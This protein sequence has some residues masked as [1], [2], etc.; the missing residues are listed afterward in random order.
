MIIPEYVEKLNEFFVQFP[1]IGGKS[2]SRLA[3][4][5]L[6]KSEQELADIASLFTNLKDNV[7]FCQQ[8]FFFARRSNELCDICS[9]SKRNDSQIL[10]V[11]NKIDVIAIEELNFFQGK[12]HILDG[13]ISPLKNILPDNLNITELSK[14]IEKLAKTEDKIEI[15][16]AVNT[17]IEGE[18]TT[19]YIS[20][21]IKNLGFSNVSISLLARGLPTGADLDY[22]D[23]DTLQ[24][25]L[26]NRSVI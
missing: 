8:C 14:R 15:I 18:A 26:V 10:V 16:L 20:N 5:T 4:F 17:N 13:L 22:T 9:S 3:F 19:N 11:E 6:N 7:T 25:S 2:A 24:N 1:G 12:Y 21:Y 23:K